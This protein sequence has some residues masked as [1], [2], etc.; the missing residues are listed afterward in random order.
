MC[1]RPGH[2]WGS[3]IFLQCALNP[4]AGLRGK[5]EEKGEAREGR[6]RK[7]MGK[8]KGGKTGKGRDGRWKKERG[9]E[10]R[11]RRRV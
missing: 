5:G 7:G 2:R 10:W 8:G 3:V 1:L 4:S 6:E 9:V 11:R